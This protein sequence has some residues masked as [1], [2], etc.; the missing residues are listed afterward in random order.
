[1][2]HIQRPLHLSTTNRKIVLNNVGRQNKVLQY[3]NSTL[4]AVEQI[5]PMFEDLILLNVIQLIYPRLPKHVK[6]YYQLKLGDRRLMDIR[7]DIFN[8]IK[9]FLQEMD[10]TEQLNALKLTAAAA[11]TTTD[12][13]ASL[14][15]ISALQK[16]HGQARVQS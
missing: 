5:G 6:E 16:F 10:L 8:N 3:N 11:T 4:A 12:P 9:K 15:A 7:T 14:S 1:M 13:P 2:I